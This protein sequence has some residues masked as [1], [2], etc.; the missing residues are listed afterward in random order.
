MELKY[1]TVKEEIQIQRVLLK[2][3]KIDLIIVDPLTND[4]QPK[5]FKEHVQIMGLGCT[6]D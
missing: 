4:S 5:T 6:Y 2:N 3:I 1:F